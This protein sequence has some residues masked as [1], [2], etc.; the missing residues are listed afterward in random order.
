MT[1]H[2]C[3]RALLQLSICCKRS[4]LM[5]PKRFFVN[6]HTL[7][8]FVRV[9]IPAVSKRFTSYKR[10]CNIV[11]TVIAP[12]GLLSTLSYD[13]N[14]DVITRC[15]ILLTNSFIDGPCMSFSVAE[16]HRTTYQQIKKFSSLQKNESKEHHINL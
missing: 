3:I 14:F 4:L 5:P 12:Q 2:L 13:G 16:L 11:K 15:L 7:N 10:N 8:P 9:Q 1:K 6:I